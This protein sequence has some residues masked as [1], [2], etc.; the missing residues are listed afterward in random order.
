MS[1]KFKTTQLGD[2]NDN[3]F[4]KTVGVYALGGYKRCE[5]FFAALSE[6]EPLRFRYIE[7]LRDT[8]V[9]ALILIDIPMS[10]IA[11]SPTENRSIFAF[12]SNGK[13][14]EDQKSSAIRFA[15]SSNLAGMLRGREL[16]DSS[17]SVALPSIPFLSIRARTFHG[18]AAF[19]PFSSRADK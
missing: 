2:R 7:D 1:Q 10:A 18:F 13:N 19:N 11:V 15:A 6:L 9:D 16:P 8:S 12:V 3:L 5:R 4:L 17:V 14:I